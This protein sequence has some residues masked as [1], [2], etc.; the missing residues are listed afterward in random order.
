MD[1]PSL[2]DEER[3]RLDDGTLLPMALTELRA[4]LQL[5][6]SLLAEAAAED[7]QQAADPEEAERDEAHRELRALKLDTV[8][9]CLMEFDDAMLFLHDKLLDH[10]ADCR[11]LAAVRKRNAAVPAGR[12]GFDEVVTF[13]DE[14]AEEVEGGGHGSGGGAARGHNSIAGASAP[15]DSDDDLELSDLLLAE[16]PSDWV[17]STGSSAKAS[18]AAAAGRG[19]AGAEDE[20][21]EDGL[22]PAE[23]EETLD[24]RVSAS[25]VQIKTLL[26][27]LEEGKQV[28]PRD[29]GPLPPITAGAKESGLA[30]R[31]RARTATGMA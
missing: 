2:P 3:L 21:V 16:A 20:V 1:A 27:A 12:Y 6:S 14:E 7:G 24:Q 9:D 17:S 30:A 4:M 22:D 25:R 13:D 31:L 19:S 10:E 8:A 26:R 15:N 18:S 23:D 11:R 5:H 28:G 29:G